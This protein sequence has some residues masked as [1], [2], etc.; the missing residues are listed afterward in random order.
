MVRGYFELD[1]IVDHKE[2]GNV[3]EDPIKAYGADVSGHLIGGTMF[4][5]RKRV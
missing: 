4:N 1:R 3:P 2:I 5:S